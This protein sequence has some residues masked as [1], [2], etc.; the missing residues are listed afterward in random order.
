MIK[1]LVKQ[2]WVIAPLFRLL[3][4]PAFIRSVL[5]RAYPS[6]A[7]IDQEL[8]SLLH[9]PSC[10]PGATESFR[11]FINLFNDHLAPELLEVLNVPVRLL[12]GAADPWEDPSRPPAGGINSVASKSC[13]YYLASA[14]APTM[15][16]QK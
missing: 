14:I 8:I 16:H 11:G 12:W 9:L 10:A 5:L 2:R 7:N 13:A 15:K 6:G 1:Q 4:R 3:A